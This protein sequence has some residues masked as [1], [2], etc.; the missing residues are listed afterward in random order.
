M[1]A[2]T[3]RTGTDL[4]TIFNVCCSDIG[5]NNNPHVQHYLSL[6][7]QEIT[8]EAFFQQ[9]RWVVWV[10][11]ISRKAAQGFLNNIGFNYTFQTFAALNSSQLAAFMRLAHPLGVTPRAEK[12]WLATHAIASWLI[13]FSSD[14]D[15][16]QK[17]FGGKTHGHQLDSTD[18]RR[19]FELRL[20]FIGPA[21]SHYMVKNLGGQAIK[22]DRWILEFLIWGQLNQQQLESRLKQHN[23]PLSLFD[24][25]IWSYCEMF[26]V[27]TANF[28]QHFTQKV[29]HL[30]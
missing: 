4:P 17:V 20:S 21:N 28:N 19:I 22:C 24:T 12:K 29:G 13:S 10:T 14:D 6:R 18:G 23:I 7:N 2:A 25:V 1:T 30:V 16:R 9:A 3:Q 5:G 11:G 27:R 26:I 8:R 15:F